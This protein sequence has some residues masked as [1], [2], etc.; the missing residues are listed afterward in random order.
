MIGENFVVLLGKLTRPDFREFDSGAKL[1]KAN[2][3]IPDGLGN[4]QYIKIACW[5]DMGQDLHNLRGKVYVRIHVHI[6]ES[7]YDGPCRHCGGKNKKYF[8]EVIVDNF[9]KIEE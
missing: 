8:T 3:A 5:G 6:E 1:F 7:S 9:V 2:L 4:Y